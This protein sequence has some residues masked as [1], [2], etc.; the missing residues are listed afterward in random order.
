MLRAVFPSKRAFHFV[1]KSSIGILSGRE[2]RS[3]SIA[4]QSQYAIPKTQ[5]AV[6]YEADNAPLQVRDDWPVVQPEA[7]QPGEILVRIAY[8]GVC[9]SDL[10]VWEGEGPP[11]VKLFPMIGGH[12]GAGYVAA[13]GAYTK[14]KLQVGDAVGVKW[15]AQTCLGCEDCL[16]GHETT[17]GNAGVHGLTHHGTFQQWCV[18]FA[19]HVT[20]IPKTMDLASAAPILCA[21][22][23]VY[24]A[25]K[26][27]NGSPG[28]YVV[29]PGAGGGL[30]HLACQYARAMGYKVV[31]IDSGDD[32]RKLIAS[33]G[34]NDFI[35]FK[36]GDVVDRVRA[37]TGG[38]GGHATIV[39]AGS[40]DAYK[41]PLMYLRPRG[42]LVAV[43]V[44]KD[45]AIVAPINPLIPLE[46]R[47][48]GSYVGSRQDAIEAINLA[49][50]GHVKSTFSI[51][52]LRNLPDIFERVH[53]GKVQGRVVLDCE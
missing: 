43:G 32:K 6:I 47:I 26:Q 24:K 51:E 2:T 39:V 46:Y 9:H 49:A 19:D 44:P 23:T 17:C 41:D 50:D 10:S 11:G 48:V 25:L 33:Y 28:E 13:I 35:D 45:T 29:I 14:T 21:G 52:P 30:G 53:S 1:R 27:I 15:I 22:M 3:Y 4:S 16:K 8:T 37:A 36:D 34:V 38:R 18:S 40:K 12:E 31:A 42:T 7:L 5:T 20:P